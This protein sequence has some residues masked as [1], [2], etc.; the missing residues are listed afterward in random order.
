MT[1]RDKWAKRPC[2]ERYRSFKDL[3]RLNKVILPTAGWHVVF[4]MPM[5]ESWPSSKKAI[6]SGKG[7]IQRPDLDNLGKALFDAIYDNDSCIW[8][9]RLTKRW[10]YE[11]SIEIVPL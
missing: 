2:V 3:I 4:H 10:A 11:G 1:Q 5:P 8:D 6:F 9:I 7:H